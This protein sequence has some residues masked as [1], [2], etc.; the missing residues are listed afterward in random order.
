MAPCWTV[1]KTPFLLKDYGGNTARIIVWG[2]VVCVAVYTYIHTSKSDD[3]NKLFP[4]PHAEGVEVMK[5]SD[6]EI[7][8]E[9]FQICN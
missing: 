5:V 3:S 9:V 7:G 1:K 2:F 8:K 4:P 6:S